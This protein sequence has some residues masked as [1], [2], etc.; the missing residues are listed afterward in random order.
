MIVVAP[1]LVMTPAGAESATGSV[2][3][4]LP[5]PLLLPPLFVVDWVCMVNSVQR[6][7]VKI[8][9]NAGDES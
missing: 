5:F 3:L 1:G 8:M 6:L 2:L 9:I 7:M 4:P